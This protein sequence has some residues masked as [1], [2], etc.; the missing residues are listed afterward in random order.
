MAKNLYELPKKLPEAEIAAP[1]FPDKGVLVERILSCGQATPEGE[2]Y[3]QQ[4]DEWV[5]LLQ[6]TATLR[7]EDGRSQ[8]MKP[9]DHVLIPAGERHRVES[10]SSEPP[11][12][13]LAVHGEL[14]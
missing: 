14:C 5:A 3:D 7:W 12:I 4:R 1:I 13:W 2:W 10:T 6:G 8:S 11:C 9:G